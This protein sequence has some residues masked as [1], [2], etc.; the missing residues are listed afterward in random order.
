MDDD[1]PA[2]TGIA[3]GGAFFLCEIE[4]V[5]IFV[6]AVVLDLVGCELGLISLVE[7]DG[8]S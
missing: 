5:L 8:C 3:I 2:V 1:T 4:A 6:E 7:V